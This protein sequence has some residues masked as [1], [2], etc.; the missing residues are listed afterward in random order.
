M[1]TVR[2]EE[3][4]RYLLVKRSSSASLVRN[5]ETG[6]TRYLENDRL[7]AE[8]DVSDLETIAAAVDEP[9]RGLLVGVHDEE[10]LGLLIDLS[11]EGPMAAKTLLDRY[12]FCESDLHGRL[13]ECQAAGLL[14]EADVCGER[15]YRVTE[16]C[17][18]GLEV[19][20]TGGGDDSSDE[21]PGQ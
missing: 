1:R 5:P 15:G 13:L 7:T 17:E 2:D 21:R 8:D 6:E 20:L 16:E 12:D 9:V 3:G 18:R 4:T 10:T 14:E 11:G 19:L